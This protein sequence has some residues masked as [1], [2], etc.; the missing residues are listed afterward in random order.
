MT[1]SGV[2]SPSKKTGREN[3]IIVYCL[4]CEWREEDFPMGAAAN[5]CPMC[6]HRPLGY[7]RFERGVEDEAAAVAIDRHRS[8]W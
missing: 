1:P 4:R 3:A 2:A 8:F 5:D 7:V 6:R